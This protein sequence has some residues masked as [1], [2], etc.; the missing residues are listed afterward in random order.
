MKAVDYFHKKPA[1]LNCAQAILTA[2]QKEYDISENTI[3]EFKQYGGYL[4]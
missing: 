1:L 2:W 3:L 4:S